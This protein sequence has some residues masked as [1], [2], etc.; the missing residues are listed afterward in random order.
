[1]TARPSTSLGLVRVRALVATTPPVPLVRRAD[2]PARRCQP[3]GAQV[4]RRAS[5]RLPPPPHRCTD[6]P[7]MNRRMTTS[8]PDELTR[9]VGW[10]ALS[11]T[12]GHGASTRPASAH[13]FP[14]SKHSLNAADLS[15]SHVLRQRCRPIM[16]L[17]GLLTIPTVPVGRISEQEQAGHAVRPAEQPDERR[18]VECGSTAANCRNLRWLSI[19]DCCQRCQHPAPEEVARPCLGVTASGSVAA[20]ASR[21][22]SRCPRATR[23]PFACRPRTVLAAGARLATAPPP[24]DKRE[25]A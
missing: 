3:T 25:T 5:H 17:N 13:P 18:C 14:H 11:A 21:H 12:A 23:W 2:E 8:N 4:V 22:P 16:H 6:R 7:G 20:R 19:R 15:W 9:S 10:P 1:M 24:T